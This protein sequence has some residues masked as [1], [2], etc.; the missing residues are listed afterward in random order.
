MAIFPIS[1]VQGV[2]GFFRWWGGEVAACLPARLRERL[3]RGGQRLTIEV[4]ETE[5]RFS[6]A[7]GQEQRSIGEISISA[8]GLSG[9]RDAGQRDAVARIV[10]QAGVRSAE[11]V[12]QLPRDK[13]LRRLVD[14]PAAAAENL[15]E[16]L[17]FE[18][19]RHTPFKAEEVYFDYRLEGGDAE[20]KRI[21]VDLVVVPRAIADLAVRLTS[22]WGLDPD[23]LAAGEE[24]ASGARP[25]NLLPPGVA[26]S[27]GGFGQRLTWALFALACL[28][29]ATAIY[30][31]LEH[32]REIL[33]ATEVELAWAKAEAVQVDE[34]RDQVQEILERGSF[35]VQRK[36]SERGVT[37]L[38]DELTRLLPDHTW[39]LKFGLRDG[40]LS[41][42]GYSAKPSSL[43]GL[44]EQSEMLTE[45]RFSSPVTM[46]QK[47]G[48]ERFN[49]TA[50]MT[51]RGGD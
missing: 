40:R 44:L 30:L 46:D 39:V 36:R 35:V 22:S 24:A 48:L 25:F 7:K 29:S 38:L 37:E 14:L 21:K 45:V 43:I 4:S 31:P 18:M 23:R 26:R 49:L 51:G 12:L 13:V 11:V 10:R 50:T 42:S 3:A 19:D 15:R 20:R 16:V 34:L 5:V 41:L 33:A 1:I 8:G 9:Q 2:S 17:G 6:I 27:R 28:L 32:K 47:I